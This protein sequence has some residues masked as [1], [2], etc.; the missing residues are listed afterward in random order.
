MIVRIVATGKT[1]SG[2]AA[3]TKAAEQHLRDHIKAKALDIYADLI[4][5]TPVDTGHARQG[6]QL[7]DAA[8][9]AI[10]IT[11]NI[12]YIGALNNGHSKQAPTGWIDAIVDR[13][14]R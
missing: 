1:A 2:W 6:W 5:E 12:E 4:D 3:F 13:H 8:G 11:N 14:T 9:D 7:D 10:K